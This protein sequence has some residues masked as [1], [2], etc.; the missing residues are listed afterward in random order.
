MVDKTVDTSGW[1]TRSQAADLLDVS[2]TT[3]KNW[4]KAGLL[5]P[6]KEKCDLPRGGSREVWVYDPRE[7]AKVP[8]ARRGR[9][10]S[11]PGDPGE[12]AARAF[13]MFDDGHDLRAVVTQL[14]ET[15]GTVEDLHDQWLRM[16]GS[17]VVLHRVAREEIASL[18]G[19]FD[20]V[21]GLLER[22]RQVLIART[23]DAPT[24]S[25]SPPPSPPT[26]G[27]P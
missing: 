13:E 8:S 15:P 23:T 18:V 20:G 9:A 21:A 12:V 17:E 24:I 25:A 22:L 16:G 5:H 7:L 27:E 11:I 2:H 10:K 4:D 19:P 26:E 6:R 14:R 3:L 1:L